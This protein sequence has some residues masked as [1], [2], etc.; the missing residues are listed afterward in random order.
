MLWLAV[1]KE[2]EHIAP[3]SDPAIG[4]RRAAGPQTEER[5]KGGH[6]LTSAVMAER[7]SGFLLQRGDGV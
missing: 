3:A 7:G 1:I 2:L 5:L 6:R 4:C